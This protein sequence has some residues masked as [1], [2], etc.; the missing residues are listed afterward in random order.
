MI[1]LAANIIDAEI[2]G[3]YAYI[4]VVDNITTQEHSHDFYEIFLIAAG[5]I[6]HHINGEAVLLP[7]GSLVFIRPD[8]RHYYHKHADHNCE[9]INLPFLT[10]TLDALSAFLSM[11]LTTEPSFAGPMPPTV[12][13][14][15]SERNQVSALC[16]AWGR[17][18]YR[19]QDKSQIRLAL[20][21]LLAQI[22]A[23]YF[24][25]ALNED[26]TDIPGWLNNLC[27]QMRHR[28]HAIEGRAALMRLANR[29]PEY[30]GRA[31]KKHLG[32]TPSAFI[33]NLRIDYA[34]DLLIH[35]DR[36][37]IDICHDVG[38]NN[39]SHFYHIFKTR[40]QCSPVQFRKQSR[41]SLIP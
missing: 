19:G 17:S 24:V 15:A 7:A 13:L 41:R 4:P 40:W 11:D 28:E 30:V 31:F 9:L 16:Q 2:E 33:N 26:R 8:D 22:I 27:D 35:T 3:Y 37:V 14:T 20:R 10:Q 34:S 38:F 29:T 25:E 12:L 39:L 6:F 1:R 32:I 36:P 21:A 23:T 5:S 18:L